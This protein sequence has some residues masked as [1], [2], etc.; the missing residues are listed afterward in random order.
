MIEIKH[1]DYSPILKGLLI[2]YVLRVY[3]EDAITDD[4]HLLM[5]YNLLQK[6]NEL[7][8]LF[9]EEYLINWLN[10]GTDDRG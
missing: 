6:N 4:E 2:D 8:L 3:E 5:E 1:F 10:D 9:H 7:H